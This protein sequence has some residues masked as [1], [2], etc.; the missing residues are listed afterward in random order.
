MPLCAAARLLCNA[1]VIYAAQRLG[2]EPLPASRLTP[3]HCPH[4]CTISS[5]FRH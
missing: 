5:S 2:L 3:T 4:K 1:A